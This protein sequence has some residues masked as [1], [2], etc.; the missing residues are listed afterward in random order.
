MITQLTDPSPRSAARL[1]GESYVAIF[2]LAIFANFFVRVRLVEPDAEA[3]FANIT[4]VEALLRSAIVAFL[5]VFL[6]DV[7]IS[8]ALYH[9]FRGVGDAISA[10]A[11]W[12]RIVYTVFLGVV[13]RRRS[14]A[15]RRCSSSPC[16]SWSREPA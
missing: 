14:S 3:T 8:W 2:A 1:A 11:S 7:V 9:V 15:S 5:V 6:L 10:L 13:P 4:E 16:S 12:F